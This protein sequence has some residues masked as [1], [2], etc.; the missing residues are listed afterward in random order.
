MRIG[1]LDEPCNDETGMDLALRQSLPSN[2][3]HQRS[4][5]DRMIRRR[6]EWQFQ[7]LCPGPDVADFPDDNLYR[8][9]R[10]SNS[11]SQEA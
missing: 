11:S 9:K 7:R 3:L 2:F 8:A 5:K 6:A 10:W 4:L 1:A